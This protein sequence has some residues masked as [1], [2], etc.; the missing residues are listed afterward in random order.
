M[1]YRKA[2]ITITNDYH[3]TEIALWA[4]IRS[5]SDAVLIT[6]NQAKTCKV[7]LCGIDI[8]MCGDD[9]GSRPS[10]CAG[11]NPNDDGLIEVFVKPERIM[12]GY[13][14]SE[15]PNGAGRLVKQ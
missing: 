4:R 12:D 14:Q 11:I 8:C 13:Y 10:V 6:R 2:K 15:W 3:G 5:G 7:R 9:I 1:T